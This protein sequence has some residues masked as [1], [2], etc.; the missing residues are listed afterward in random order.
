MTTA[1]TNPL[2]GGPEPQVSQI[3]IPAD[4]AQIKAHMARPQGFTSGAAVVVIHENKG[5][6]ANIRDVA[7]GLAS[8]GYLAV[9]PDLLSREGPL[10]TV[11]IVP[12]F[13]KSGV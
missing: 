13:G 8:S 2:I 10:A 6:V 12:R 4:G 11:E 9:A 5:L 1:A 3:E 7:D